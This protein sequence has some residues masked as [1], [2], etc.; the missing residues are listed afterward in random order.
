MRNNHESLQLKRLCYLCPWRIYAQK[1]TNLRKSFLARPS[2]LC[3]GFM[4]F[5]F[6]PELGY[7]ALLNNSDSV[8]K[9]LFFE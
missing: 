4:N 9:L 3:D 7:T 6:C 5:Y 1:K 8:M 2:A